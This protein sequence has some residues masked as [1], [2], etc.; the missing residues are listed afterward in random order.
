M[1]LAYAWLDQCLATTEPRTIRLTPPLLP[2]PMIAT[3]TTI[4]IA[5]PISIRAHW[6]HCSYLL[7]LY[8]TAYHWCVV[9]PTAHLPS[10]KNCIRRLIGNER[11]LT[12][13]EAR[14]PLWPPDFSA[15]GGTESWRPMC[16]ML[17][18]GCFTHAYS[19]VRWESDPLRDRLKRR[20]YIRSSSHWGRPVLSKLD[21]L[22]ATRHAAPQEPFTFA[23]KFVKPRYSRSPL[24]SRDVSH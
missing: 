7:F 6:T 18:G 4:S 23:M 19:E 3:L 11:H 15:R 9:R 13:Q 22:L 1:Y 21:R 24:L 8:C 14:F 5:V 20:T 16:A 12:N 17:C 2:A 10:E